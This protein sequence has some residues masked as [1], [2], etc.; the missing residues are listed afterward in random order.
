MLRAR[1]CLQL[2]LLIVCIAFA[3]VLFAQTPPVTVLGNQTLTF[4]EADSTPGSGQAAFTS[5]VSGLNFRFFESQASIDVAPAG[6]TEGSPIRLSLSGASRRPHLSPEGQLPGIVSYFPSPDTRTWRTNLRTWSGLRY[7][8]IY[9]GID[10][11]YYGSRGQL[12]YD[13]VVAPQ[14]DP[15]RIALEIGSA[16][17]VSITPDGGLNISGDGASFRFSKPVVYQTAANGSRDLVAGRYVMK[18]GGRIGFDI[19]NWDRNRPLVIDP[20]LA[21]SSFVGLTNSDSF[22]AEA[23]DSSNNL[24]LAGRSGGVLLVEK[25]SSDGTTVVYRAVF[26]ATP[27]YTATVEDIRVDAAGKAYIVGTSGPNFPTTAGG[28]LTSVTSGSHAFVAVLNAAGTTLSYATYLA[29]T[30]SAQDQANGVAVDSTNKL[31]YVTGFTNSTTFP[32]TTGVFQTKNTNNGQT[33]FVAKIDPSKSGVASLIYSTYLSGPTAASV[34]NAIDIDA[35]GD[36]Y[37][38]GTAGAD[39]PTT[40]GAFQYNGEGLGQG[41]VYVTKLNPTATGLVYSAY[42][43]VGQANGI[44]V[45]G[46]GDAYVAGTVG[47]EDFPTTT[48]AYQIIYPSGFASELNSTGSALVY[49][50]FLSGPSQLTTPTDIAIEPGCS[51]ACNAFITGYTSGDDLPLTAPIQDFNA[52]FVNGTTG[53]DAFVTQLNGTGTAAVYSTFIGGSSDES[54]QSTAHSPAIAA[55]ATGDAFVVGTTSSPDFP[56]TLTTT[57][58]RNT[59]ALRIGANAA[60]TAVV[61]PAT[62]AFSTQQPVGVASTPLVVTLRNMGSSAMSITS[63]TPSPSD[64]S[65]TDTCGSSLARGGECAINVS[66]KPSTAAARPGT[67]TIT[68][69]GGNNPNVVNLTGTGVNQAFITLTPPSLTFADQSVGTA[70]PAQMVTVGN[71]AT[72]SLTLGSS[73]FTIGSNFAQTNNCPASLAQGNTCTVSIAFLPTQNGPFAGQLTVTSNSSGFATSS[74]SL[75]GTGFVGAPALT[76]SSAGLVFNPQVIGIAGPAQTVIVSNTGNVPVTIYGVSVNSLDYT[77]TGCVQTLNPGGV[78]G[79]RVTFKPTAAGTRSGKVI[80]ADSTQAGTHSF[81][82]TGTGVTQTTTLAINPPALLF[83]DLAVGATSTPALIIQVTNTSNAPVAINRVFPTGDFRVSSTACVTNLRAAGTCTIGVE[84]AP[85]A[86]GTR[87]GTIVIEDTATG[88]PQSVKLSGNGITAAPAAIATPGGIA[89]DQQAQGTISPNPLAVNLTNTGNL[90]FDASNVSITGTN[91]GDFQISSQGCLSV[92]LNPGRVCQVQVTFT[93]TATGN[94]K[95]T[96]T[97]TNAA[98]TQTANLTGAGV[99]ATFS[100]GFTPAS[101]TFQPQQKGVASPAQTFWLRNTGSGA[102]TVTSIASGTTDYQ[103][104]GCVG[105]PIQPNTSCQESVSLTPTVTT[106]DNSTLTVTSNATGSPQVINLTGSG[107]T[108]LPAM[109]LLPAGLAYNNQVVSTTSQGQSVSLMN[110]SGATVTGITVAA[111]GT[112]SADFTI[113]GNNCTATLNS[114][115][116]CSFQVAFKPSAAGAR[117]ASVTINDSIGTQTV[118]LAGFAVASTTSALLV[119]NALTFPSETTGFSSPAQQITFRNTGNTPFIIS[120]VVLGGTNPGDF[121][122]S[123][124]CP[125]S[126]NQFNAFSSCNTSVTFTP[127]TTGTRTATVT[128]TDA[129]P[130]SPRTITLTGKGVAPSQGLEVGPA[131][132]AFPPQVNTTVSPINYNV[133][134]TNTGTSPVTISS[135]VLGG[136]NPGD[137]GLSNGCPGSLAPPPSGNTCNVNVSFT[138]TATGTR[139]A[140]ITVTDSAPGSPTTVTLSGKGVA[141]TKTLGVTP[142]TLVFDPQVTGTTSAQ[143]FITVTNTGNFMITFTNVTITT[144]FALSNSCTGS[145]PPASSCSIGVTFTPTATGKTTG[146]VSIADNVTGSPQTVALTGTGLSTSKVIQLSQ[147]S[148]VFDPQTMSTA[149]PVQTVYYSNQGNTTVTINTLTQADTEFSLS[150]S[151][152]TAGA[153]VAAQSFCTFRIT[154][155]PSA[156]GTRSSTLSIADTAPGSPRTI[157]LS[158]VGIS[159]SMPEVNLTPASL[160]FATQAEGST[161]AAQNI[162]LT[163]NGSADLTITNIAVAGANLSDFAQTNSC[164]GTLV[165]GFSC[166]IAV[167]F[168]PTGIGTRTAS[169]KVTDNAAGSPHSV[170]LTGTGKAGPLPVVTLSPTSL[171]FPN[172]MVNSSKKKTVTVTNSGAAALNVSVVTVTGTVPSNFSQT[173]NCVGVSVAVNGTCTIT[174]TFA[175]TTLEDQTGTLTLTDNAADSPQTVPIT[176]SGAEAAVDISP[177]ALV[178]ASQGVGTTSAAQTLTVENYGN[179]TLNISG[180]SITGPFLISNNTCGTTLGAGLSCTISIQFKPTQTGAANGDLILND[181]AGDSPQFVAL[182]GTGS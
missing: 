16:Q 168:S 105:F 127:T 55:N 14:R 173:N 44:A 50:T 126:P 123:S 172:V 38:A 78:C 91:S 171:K 117:T 133:L 77:T 106:T 1:V 128:I 139:T 28:F 56:V 107:A 175:P 124:G 18:S 88:S 87:K 108:S 140:T 43:G 8:G 149:S 19:P 7:Q 93:P 151:S 13:F 62:L 71:L 51:T 136:T 165:A 73:A 162:N 156:V 96:L 164:G 22:T 111:A 144:G 49:S 31:I 121:S 110:N 33:A 82:V 178:F 130:G 42:L 154:F 4:E 84:F 142:T 147:T 116:Q 86:T 37:V 53:N 21:W 75:S 129:A 122:I 141:Q 9:P 70:S 153:Q 58:Q 81:T 46:S 63:I 113:S 52:S 161:S 26:T 163:N 57:T 160:T 29:G 182:S 48:G 134:L 145:L 109:Q 12:E 30:T 74:V 120:S 125:I 35:S 3:T 41:G 131:S 176:G 69:A 95:A 167:T 103:A 79:V 34:E 2:A 138:P 99:T 54:T 64:Y 143:Q 94:R 5:S 180:V 11:V 67:L 80:L 146:T 59:F 68:H 36:A 60:A 47:V 181:D 150:G 20:V 90:P 65:E 148:V 119:D 177:D 23:V 61:F 85:T 115:S 132:I 27:S 104:S 170:A 155:T 76:L 159:S 24:Y 114:A 40:A 32:T 6:A 66:F 83:A 89:F 45:D 152:C 174:V 135:I 169:V 15:K 158:G 98:G 166:N 137:F 118:S 102:I 10:L 25:I 100:L 101:L 157:K 112:N 97:F 17:Q 72:T 92:I 179:A 39:F